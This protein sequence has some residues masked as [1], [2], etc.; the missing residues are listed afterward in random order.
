MSKIKLWIL[1]ATNKIK[2]TP[3]KWVQRRTGLRRVVPEDY[4]PKEGE[5]IIPHISELRPVLY[6][7]IPWYKKKFWLEEA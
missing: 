6:E 4:E 2:F 7:R 1:E 5:R 3:G